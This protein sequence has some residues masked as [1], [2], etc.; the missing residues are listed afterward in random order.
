MSNVINVTLS[1][2]IDIQQWKDMGFEIAENEIDEFAKEEFMEWIREMSD[3]DIYEC[4]HI[5][6]VA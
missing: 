3:I 4:L 1:L 2:D 6:E 5:R